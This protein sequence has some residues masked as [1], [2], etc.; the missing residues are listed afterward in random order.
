MP[1]PAHGDRNRT[2]SSEVGWTAVSEFA[3]I[4]IGMYPISDRA[5]MHGDELRDH[6]HAADE[7]GDGGRGVPDDGAQAKAD[8][9]DQA[10]ARP[11]QHDRPQHA[12]L[13]ERGRRDAV[14]AARPPR[15]RTR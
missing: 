4:A 10:E 7:H 1:S 9:P 15:R 14:P 12:G 3:T 11:G 8:Q 13:A 6:V 2:W 5:S